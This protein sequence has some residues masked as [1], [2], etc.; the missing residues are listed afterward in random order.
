[1]ANDNG[2]QHPAADY[3]IKKARLSA[4]MKAGSS[5]RLSKE[6]SNLFRSR[7]NG[8]EKIL[9]A[10]DFNRV[11]RVN[12][13]EGW[14]E[15]EGM[16]TYEDFVNQTLKFGLMPAVVPQ[17]KT[18][19][20]GGAATGVGIESTSFRYG[21]VHE[22]LIE[23][24]IL[25]SSGD[26]VVCNKYEHADLFY[27]FPNSYGTFGYALK[28]KV[29]LIPVKLYVK[30]EHARY[31]NSETYFQALGTACR[32]NFDFVDGVMFGP[33]EM[34][35]TTGKFVD[36]SPFVS[37]YTYLDIYYKSIRVKKEDYLSVHNY[38]WRWDTDWFWCSNVFK[39][40]KPVIRR[41][42]GK[43]RLNSAFYGKIMK[44]D[45]KYRFS[46]RFFP[47][48]G[49]HEEWVIQDVDIPL[50]N[51]PKFVEFFFREI[52]IKPVWVCPIGSFD[53]SVRFPLYPLS[54]DKLYVNFGFWG[55]V[56]TDKEKGFY[57]KLVESKVSEFVGRKGLY[58][59]SFYTEEDFW[60][61]YNKPAYDLLKQ[62]YDPQGK[63]K[64]LYD[65]CVRKL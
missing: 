15:V 27:G 26:T 30:I 58:S 35:V 9:S 47:L 6:T 53:K 39:A 2:V 5:V 48:F 17:L 61:I 43:K 25:L 29:K 14:A 10:R 3:E 32:S 64:N 1:M 19:T 46:E 52:G 4:Q 20:I 54:P 44:W 51:A 36:Q 59:D 33:G 63:L 21:L 7:V 45:K 65:K 49:I 34:Y 50:D 16:T 40:Q 38:L 62:K 57:N 56:R 42:L 41:L 12:K 37:D 23:M 28:L 11:L 18:I 24:E 22:T 55:P 13:D 60:K 8:G 31:D